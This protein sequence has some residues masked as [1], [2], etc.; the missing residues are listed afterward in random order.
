MRGAL[1]ARGTRRESGP[2]GSVAAS[3][4]SHGLAIGEG[5]TP[6]SWSVLKTMH[7]DIPGWSLPTHRR[8]T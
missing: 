2:G 7:T 1:A 6:E 4:P 8:R 3:T 5:T